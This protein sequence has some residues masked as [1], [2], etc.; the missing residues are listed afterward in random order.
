[1]TDKYI[2]GEIQTPVGNILQVSTKLNI[3][4]YLGTVMVR[5]SIN[6]DNYKVKPGLYAVGNPTALSDVFVT[7]NYK[8]SFDHL[9]KNLADL[10]AWLLILDTRG[11]NV[12]CAAG[13]GTFGSQEL[14]NRI[15][16]TKLDAV[17]SH[18]RIILPQLGAVGISAFQV[19]KATES[20][21]TGSAII[22][23]SQLQTSKLS[24]S[25]ES[26]K[27]NRGFNVVYGPVRA[28]DIKEFINNGYKA[29]KEM[30]KVTFNF[31]D[32]IKLIPVD[33]VYSRYRLLLAFALI[34]IL[35]GLSRTGLSFHL[36]YEK[37]LY[38]LLN[39]FLAYVSG[40]VITPALLPYIPV[41]SFAFKGFITGII[42]STVLLSFNKLGSSYP[43]M[44]SWFLLISGI[45][46]FL[47]MNF[48]GSS[49]YTSLSG[50]KKEMKVAVPIQIAF[51]IIGL[52]L[53]VVGKLK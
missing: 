22:N 31:T 34:F 33:L 53:F 5:W 18:R 37:G 44:L 2:I 3:E 36:A 45:S 1:M 28:K 9:R 51:S 41:R 43:E 27:T 23:P 30:R 40:I 15:R 25:P 21:H 42:L 13:K 26:L 6:R 46:S 20:V 7:A 8:L 17:I 49:T 11:I 14:I 48:T 39:L 32:R 16:L 47:A 52:I 12:W 35:S 29:T 19:K 38:G 10:N 50:V 24:F 4:D